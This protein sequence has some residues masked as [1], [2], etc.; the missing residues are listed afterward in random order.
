VRVLRA[1]SR[2]RVDVALIAAAVLVTAAVAAIAALAGDSERISDYWLHASLTPS[3]PLVVEVIDY[4]FGPSS[5]RGILRDIDDLAPDAAILVSSPT[6]PDD[7]LVSGFGHAELRIGDPDVT[8][9]GRHRYRIEYPIAAVLEGTQLAWDAVGTRWDVGI[10]RA[11]IHVTAPGH[12]GSVRCVR[13]G[14][15]SFDVCDI[16]QV[17]PGHLVAIV[18]GIDAREGVTIYAEVLDASAVVAAPVEPS[19]RPDDPG[20]GW[21]PPLAVA[22]AAALVGAGVAS[23]LVRSLGKEQVWEGGAADAAFGP[24]RDE[25]IE[26][27]SLD[28][29]ELAEMATIEFE[30]PRGLSAAAGGIIQVEQVAP[31]HQVAWLIECAI[32]D[33][34][35]LDESGAE[36]VLRR[37]SAK[38]DEAVAGRLADILGRG[39]VTLGSYDKS[40]ATAWGRLHDDLE[41]WRDAS[42]LWDGAG[43]VRRMS[44]RILGAIGVVVGL[45]PLII[46]AVLANRSGRPWLAL[47]AAG[48]IVVGASLGV[49]I[50]SWELRVRTPEGSA[51]WLQVESFRRFIANSEA[52]HAEAAAKMGLL[53]QY[54]AWAVSLNELDHWE[55][56]VEEAAM[57]A[58][59]AV[60]ASPSAFD[61]V[62][63]APIL[64]RSTAA[65]STAPSSSGSGGG[66][67]AGG[68]GGG[69][70]GGS[71]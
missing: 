37:G 61:F 23:R 48:A 5:R 46:G 36:I 56:A 29:A 11:E 67:G 39:S 14:V 8:I 28:H 66:G 47:L 9:R 7:L 18:K 45:V 60:Q 55:K 42:G 43:D 16:E 40:F 52:R 19:G 58:G 35:V 21:L 71:W 49:L 26:T 25:T 41:N 2:R 31:R 50:R 54:T 33:E 1:R 32:R 13:G 12:F 24:Q 65:A 70:G 63:I 53:R 38:P 6:A 64:S 17:E 62:H 10:D 27:R 68:G 22:F 3:G 69:G 4:D 20:T 30:A 57:V 44:A 15:G 59:S 51:R 34:V